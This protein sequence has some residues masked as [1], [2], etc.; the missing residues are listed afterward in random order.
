MRITGYSNLQ[1]RAGR[2]FPNN[3]PARDF[4]ISQLTDA[5]NIMETG[6]GG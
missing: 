1:I 2:E 3:F 6:I 5:V 4:S